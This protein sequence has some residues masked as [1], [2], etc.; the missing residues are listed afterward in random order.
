MLHLPLFPYYHPFLFLS[1]LF[2]LLIT[3]A[4]DP[5]YNIRYS[6]VASH[7]PLCILS[8]TSSLTPY[9]F[10]LI[11]FRFTYLSINFTINYI[12]LKKERLL[13]IDKLFTKTCAKQSHEMN[14]HRD[15][16]SHEARWSV[17]PLVVVRLP[18]L[19]STN[20]VQNDVKQ[21][22]EVLTYLD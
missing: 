21:E 17:S 10:C 4:K 15:K 22:F 3:I 13:I 9:C 12:F 19:T 16:S 2:S 6:S 8:C 18:T 1:Y 7:C 20:Q 5:T 11:F 14:F